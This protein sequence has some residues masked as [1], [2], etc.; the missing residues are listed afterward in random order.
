MLRRRFWNVNISRKWVIVFKVL[1]S[2]LKLKLRKWYDTSRNIYADKFS[3][4]VKSVNFEMANNVATATRVSEHTLG[5]NSC[6]SS[7]RGTSSGMLQSEGCNTR[8]DDQQ[9]CRLPRWKAVNPINGNLLN[10]TEIKMVLLNGGTAVILKA[11]F[12]LALVFFFF[13]LNCFFPLLLLSAR[14]RIFSWRL[15][16]LNWAFI[17]VCSCSKLSISLRVASTIWCFR[18]YFSVIQFLLFESNVFFSLRMFFFTFF[19][20]LQAG[21]NVRLHWKRDH[22]YI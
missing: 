12:V 5:C 17:L 20:S 6:S 3:I 18:E 10:Y 7:S 21:K 1:H 15:H 9:P 14:L 22:K 13:L 8:A 11:S 2:R 4:S 16:C 19:S